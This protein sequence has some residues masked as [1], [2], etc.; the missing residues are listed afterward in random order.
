MMNVGM[1][2]TASKR[3]IIGCLIIS[4]AKPPEKK[5]QTIT[6]KK[7]FFICNL[8]NRKN[9]LYFGVLTHVIIII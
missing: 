3:I 4:D 1:H 6:K 9:F 7:L 5:F 8:N 2:L